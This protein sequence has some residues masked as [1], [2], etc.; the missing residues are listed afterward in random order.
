MHKYEYKNIFKT[1][2][3]NKLQNIM[4]D[5]SDTERVVGLFFICHMDGK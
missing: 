2:T 5:K 3:K 4:R 1:I